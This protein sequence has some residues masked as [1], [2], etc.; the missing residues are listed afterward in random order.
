MPCFGPIADHLAQKAAEIFMSGEGQ[1]RTG[2]PSASPKKVE[3]KTHLR[4]RAHLCFH[5]VKLIVEPPRG[6]GLNLSRKAAI[7]KSFRLLLR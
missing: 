5:P 1:E 3:I 4:K 2:C 7:L 6:S